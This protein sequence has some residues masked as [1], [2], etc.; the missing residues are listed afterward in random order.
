MN[1][2]SRLSPRNI[3]TPSALTFLLIIVI[4][5][6]IYKTTMSLYKKHHI[7]WYECIDSKAMGM[8][9]TVLYDLN[10]RRTF[11]PTTSNLILPCQNKYN[12]NW[13]KKVCDD[14]KI[15]PAI[16]NNYL[17]GSK[18]ALWTMLFRFYGRSKAETIMPPSYILPQDTKILISRHI[19]D[20][21]YV[22]KNEQQRQIG[23]EITKDIK[24]VL[25]SNKKENVQ[26]KKGK[27]IYIHIYYIL[28]IY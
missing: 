23:L 16:P 10:Y 21:I 27:N 17:F 24:E 28:I 3:S 2:I 15:I 5:L 19:T 4:F 7:Q 1:Y 6:F 20:N 22:L 26:R 11:N 25:K 14:N 13:I 12:D 9:R 8:Y 18:K